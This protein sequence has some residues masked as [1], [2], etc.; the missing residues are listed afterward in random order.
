MCA[1]NG[2]ALGGGLELALAC[3]YRVVWDSPKVQ[4]GLPEVKLG[5][6]PG[7]GGTV[8]LPRLVGL[9]AALGMILAGGSIRPQKALAMGLVDEIVSS[10]PGVLSEAG[11]FLGVRDIA[12][13]MID[14]NVSKRSDTPASSLSFQV[15]FATKTLIARILIEFMSGSFLE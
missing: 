11:F 5:L 6:L 4:L 9:Q 12:I 7:A 15:F 3:D 13:R 14:G 8:R 10:G 2:A 1:I